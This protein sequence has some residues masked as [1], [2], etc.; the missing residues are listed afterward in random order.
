MYSQCPEC[1][2]RF[3]VTAAALRAAHGT[4]RCG[5]C[6]SA[7]D[8]LPRL[9]DRLREDEAGPAEPASMSYTGVTGGT[10][11][12]VVLLA[13][14][15]GGSAPEFHFSADDIERVFIDARDWQSRF[16]NAA[17]P[18]DRA[19]RLQPLAELQHLLQ[20]PEDSDE[21]PNDAARDAAGQALWVHEPEAVEDITLE[22]ER[23][24]IE[25]F[26]GLEEDF[27]EREI[28]NAIEEQQ[29]AETT[30]SRLALALPDADE[31]VAGTRDADAPEG[32]EDDDQSYD[33][34]STDR[35]AIL[36]D[37]PDSAYPDHEAEPAPAESDED[38]TDSLAVAPPPA[39]A[40]SVAATVAAAGVA[41][42]AA[43]ATVAAAVVRPVEPV[44]TQ[45]WRRPADEIDSI[46]IE[47]HDSQ[48][49]D[50]LAA[51]A[52][53]GGRR[54]AWGIGALL[55]AALLAAQLAHHFREPLARDPRVGPAVRATYARLGMPLA[56]NWNL[57]AYELRQW[58][59]SETAP[60]SSG[61]MVVRGSIRNGAQFAQPMPLLRLEFEDRFGG[62]VAR[63]DFA[64]A[65]YLKDAGQATRLLAPG[66]A[67]EAELAIVDAAPDAVGYRLDVCLRDGAGLVR[68][69]QGSGASGQ[70]SQ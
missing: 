47:A 50:E 58:G 23:I 43:P 49:A 39:V 41:T 40:T 27:L 61:E 37:V 7:F 69:A 1:S 6:G 12:E 5:R 19:A 13:T 51:A 54:W 8:A 11:A 26:E 32:F 44:S 30:G 29:R 34:D 25:G 21:Q 55:L 22:G 53:A 17:S 2:T 42:A 14:A 10:A 18:G 65:D 16:G 36:D 35:F 62:T 46:P 63:R 31:P 28:E 68:C 57:A 24:Q 45:R 20:D 67:V 15:A 38:R 60:S 64:P 70:A 66:A 3:R 52:D 56:P 48:L 59:A 33:L 4:V 9:T